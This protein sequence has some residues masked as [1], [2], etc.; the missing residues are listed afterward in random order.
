MSPH[1]YWEDLM[2]TILKDPGI[3]SY[4]GTNITFVRSRS[5]ICWV[6]FFTGA[7]SLASAIVLCYFLYYKTV[8]G[9]PSK[10]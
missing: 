9:G 10:G 3:F 5:C 7:A 2:T 6:I 4:K 8:L 1:H